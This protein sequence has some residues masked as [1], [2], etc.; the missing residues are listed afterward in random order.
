[1]LQ[2]QKDTHDE[3]PFQ[4][5][6]TG[7]TGTVLLMFKDTKLSEDDSPNANNSGDSKSTTTTL[8]VW[9]PVS[10]VQAI[11]KD[12]RQE[13]ES[14]S[15]PSSAVSSGIRMIPSSRFV[16]RIIPIQKTC[17]T[18]IQDIEAVLP[19]LLQTHI[20]NEDKPTK[21]TTTPKTTYCIHV[22]KRN[23]DQLSRQDLIDAAVPIVT[24][25]TNWKVQLA[26]PD[27][28]IWIEVCKTLMGISVLPH[29][30]VQLA[31]NLNMAELRRPAA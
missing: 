4:L 14:P 17:F 28:M 16:T 25:L 31:K 21:G 12:I 19:S 15:S 26:N 27:Y 13:N 24:R 7:C 5:F 11:L 3:G 22:K 6:S 9:D 20:E 10:T 1:M 30:I 29:D 23:F 18:S 2:K 8:N